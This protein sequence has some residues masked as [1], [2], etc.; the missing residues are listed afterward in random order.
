MDPRTLVRLCG[1]LGGLVW[2]GR[3]VLDGRGAGAAVLGSTYGAGLALLAIA[4]AG[5]G[6]GLAGATWLRALVA[7]CL[8]LLGWSVLV[9]L[10]ESGREVLVDG[11]LGVLALLVWVP[12][13]RQSRRR[14]G[15]GS[16]AA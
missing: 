12:L 7:V 3:W 1:V 5:T 16:H 6:A 4:L 9:V 13:L 14:A 8:P 15:L 10:H 11:L 2:V